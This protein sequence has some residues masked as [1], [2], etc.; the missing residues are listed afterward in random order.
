M[1]QGA[2]PGAGTQEPKPRIVQYR[3]RRY[4]I[5]L[6]PVFW[7]AL[8]RLAERSRMRLGRF[9]AE[10]AGRY[11]GSNFSS[12]LRVMCML[13]AELGLARA[14]LRPTQS[15]VMDL[16]EASFSPGLVLSRYR[17]IIAYNDGFADWLGR[18][19]APASGAD[20]TS[21]IQVRTRRPLNDVWLEMIAGTIASVDANVLHVQPGRVLAAAARFVALQPQQDE[22]FYAVL[23]IST[24]RRAA[25]E[26]AFRPVPAPGSAE[27]GPAR[28]RSDR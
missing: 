13:E 27:R 3:N 25:P 16:V 28:R 11:R 26:A 10:A 1:P 4:S 12:H 19:R 2:D 21:V 5:R 23:W 18:D 7:Q 8:D 24:G 6:E 22:E 9:V 14:S 20:L 15:N 17:T